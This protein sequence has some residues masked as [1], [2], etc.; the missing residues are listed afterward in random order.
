MIEIQKLAWEKVQNLMPAIIQ[1]AKTLQVLMLGYVNPEALQKTLTDR[2][3]TFYSRTKQRLWTKGETSGNFLEL[4]DVMTDCDNDTLLFLV[5]PAG[6]CCHLNNA[7]CFSAI[8]APGL[9]FLAKLSD[10]ITKRYEQRSE[11]SY[12]ARLFDKGTKR[13][14]QKVGEEGVEVALAAVAQDKEEVMNEAADL[15]YHLLILLKQVDLDIWNILTELRRR[16][17]KVIDETA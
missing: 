9:G 6:P 1:D 13:I 12:T 4:V 14:A 2:K 15:I 16:Q 7:S 3:I 10:L 17:K 11:E 5:N 8:E